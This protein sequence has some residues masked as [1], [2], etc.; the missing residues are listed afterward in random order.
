MEKSFSAPFFFFFLTKLFSTL[1]SVRQG[2]YVNR[3]ELS[4][5]SFIKTQKKPSENKWVRFKYNLKMSLGELRQNKHELHEGWTLH[6]YEWAYHSAPGD[7]R[8]PL[9]NFL[10]LQIE[11]VCLNVFSLSVSNSDT[12]ERQVKSQRK[13]GMTVWSETKHAKSWW[14]VCWWQEAGIWIKISFSRNCSN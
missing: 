9:G 10:S 3:E 8:R 5:T 13:G 12:S 11:L 14:L 2:N 7:R 4:A 6:R 1:F